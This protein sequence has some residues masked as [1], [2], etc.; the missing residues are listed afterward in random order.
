[1]A[2]RHYI[3][4]LRYVVVVPSAFDMIYLKL[5]SLWF[6]FFFTITLGLE[7]LPRMAT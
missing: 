3:W 6:L 7:S 2:I 1:M 4:Q 5:T